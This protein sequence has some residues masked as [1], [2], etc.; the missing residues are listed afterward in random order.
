MTVNLNVTELGRVVARS[1][2]LPETARYFIEFLISRRDDL[3]SLLPRAVDAVQIFDEQIDEATLSES[4]RALSFVVSHLVFS[5]TEYSE[6]TTPAQRFIPFMLSSTRREPGNIHT[7]DQIL[8]QRWD[9]DLGAVN[10]TE[11]SL[12]FSQG[13][14]LSELEGRFEGLTSGMIH[15]L[16]RDHVAHLKGLA[17]IIDV[18]SGG[19]ISRD[20]PNVSEL[21]V[22]DEHRILLRRVVR[23]I[24]VQI[25][26]LVHGVPEDVMWMREL[27]KENGSR[28]MSRAMVLSLRNNGLITLEDILDG[29]KKNKFHSAMNAVGASDVQRDQIRSATE[30]QRRDRTKA[31]LDRIQAQLPQCDN[32]VSQLF[33][34]RGQDYESYLNDCFE[35]IGIKV[36]QRDMEGGVPRFPD[37]V[38]SFGDGGEQ[39]CI[40]L[41]CKSKDNGG[42]VAL[43]EATD[44]GGKAV[45]HGLNRMPMVTVCQPY[46]STDVSRHLKTSN[47]LSVVNAEDL[48]WALAAL[49]QEKITI[50]RFKGWLTTPGQPKIDDLFG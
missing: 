33:G 5:S 25:M 17:D 39:D 38:L 31:L 19:Q 44:V 7:I 41:E 13:V 9:R 10:A 30:A 48:A 35:C 4:E 24:R 1:G 6:T 20:D 29:G 23:H 34:S 11:L 43:G 36:M 8:V 28:L 26:Q 37:F 21:I 32:L 27:K 47:D 18:L 40:V 46:V 45:T 2:L 49:K 12:D 22:N 14:S 50:Q 3:L 15:G 16:L 42:E